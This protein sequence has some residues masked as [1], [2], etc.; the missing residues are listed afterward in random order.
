MGRCQSNGVSH[1]ACTPRSWGCGV[2]DKRQCFEEIAARQQQPERE[3]SVFNSNCFSMLVDL[4]ERDDSWSSKPGK[5]GLRVRP[6]YLDVHKALEGDGAAAVP[7][8]S[9]Q[10][11]ELIVN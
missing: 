3:F 8:Q 4:G 2:E 10:L 7:H 11:G 9:L 1:R 6:S 5:A